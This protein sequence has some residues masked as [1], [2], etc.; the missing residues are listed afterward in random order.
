MSENDLLIKAIVLSIGLNYL[1][2]LSNGERMRLDFSKIIPDKPEFSV[3]ND[4]DVFY[5]GEIDRFHKNIIFTENVTLSIDE[6]LKYGVIYDSKKE[7]EKIIKEIYKLAK[8][9]RK[10]QR[11]T[12]KQVSSFIDIP[13]SGIARIEK[14]ETD[15][16]LSTLLYYLSPLGLTLTVTSKYHPNK[17]TIDAMNEKDSDKSYSS[18]EEL[19]KGLG[20]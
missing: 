1:I 9:A 8:E 17:K 20:L 13:Q 2:L 11:I 10:N 15:V 5:Y 12:Q 3:I 14:G 6:I 19:K 16:Q 18:V 4:L 7:N